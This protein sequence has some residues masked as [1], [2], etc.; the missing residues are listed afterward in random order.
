V[1][2]RSW[3]R[4]AR[5]SIASRPTPVRLSSAAIRSPST[6]ELTNPRTRPTVPRS[7]LRHSIRSMP[8]SGREREG[9]PRICRVRRQALTECI[10]LAPFGPAHRIAA[11]ERLAWRRRRG[12][13]AS[14]DGARRPRSTWR[15]GFPNKRKSGTQTLPGLVRVRGSGEMAND[16]SSAVAAG[17]LTKASYAAFVSLSPSL[18]GDRGSSRSRCAEFVRSSSRRIAPNVNTATSQRS[19]RNGVLIRLA[20][21]SVGKDPAAAGQGQ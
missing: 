20:C 10:Q 3:R 18:T 2:L 19:Q 1:R 14:P 17:N 21:R 5:A 7:A 11:T 4:P 8:P 6:D 16:R 13:V 9:V 15:A 12:G